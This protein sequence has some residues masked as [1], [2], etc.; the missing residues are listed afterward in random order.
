[1]YRLPRPKNV[2]IQ[3]FTELLSGFISKFQK[4]LNLGDSNMHVCCPSQSLVSDFMDTL[5]F[6]N[7]IQEP[8]HSKGHTLDLVIHLGLSPDNLKLKDI[9]VSDHKAILFNLVLYQPPFNRNLPVRHRTFNSMSA[10][11]F[12]ELFNTAFLTALN[13][14]FYTEELVSLFNHTCQTVL[15]TVAP[16][17]VKKVQEFTTALAK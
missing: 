8:T 3:E 4:S 9:C 7:L 12:S 5:E 15:D 10:S 14:N 1:M 2:F 11:Q 16:Y 17:K 13:P 6:F